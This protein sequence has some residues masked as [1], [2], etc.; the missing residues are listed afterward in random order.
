MLSKGVRYSVMI[1]PNRLVKFTLHKAASVPAIDRERADIVKAR[2]KLTK[3][4]TGAFSAMASKVTKQLNSLIKMDE[5]ELNRI[6]NQIDLDDYVELIGDID[7]I[8]AAIA[9]SGVDA[10]IIQVGLDMAVDFAQANELAIA[11]AKYH[12]AEMVGKKWV[13][14]VLV[15]NPNAAWSIRESTRESLRGLIVQA[16][17][18]GY[19]NQRLAKEIKEAYAFSA[20]RA[21]LIAR[22]ETA[23][24]DVMGNVI[25]Y[26]ESGVVKGKQWITAHDEKVTPD[27]AANGAQGV[28]DF[29]KAFS[30]GAM[31]PPDHP[32]CRCDVIPVLDMEKLEKAQARDSKGRFA[33]SGGSGAKLKAKLKRKPKQKPKGDAEYVD[34][35]GFTR[36]GGLNAKERKV[37]QDFYDK[38]R[39]SQAKL[40]AAYTK[41]NGHTVD[42]DL[43]KHLNKEFAHNQD[44]ARAVHEPSSHLSKII[45]N[46][47]LAEKGAA[48]DTSTTL[49]T[50]GGSGSGKS[51]TL[52]HAE[53]LLGAKS[54]GLVVDSVLSNFAS[55][56]SRIDATLKATS[57]DVGIVYTNAK[58]SQALRQNAARSRSVSIDTLLHAHAGASENVRVLA[59]HYKDNP[60][61]KVL[62][63]NN[64]GAKTDVHAGKLSDVPKYEKSTM[65]AQLVSE[66]NGMLSRGEITAQRHAL[67]IN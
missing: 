55:A 65:R 9:V 46:K 63:M 28:I 45:L 25:A 41:E 4:L 22:T 62:I 57:G 1:A 5:S 67:L 26:R 30:S 33:S 35:H 8:L 49:F 18:D 53:R 50:A 34:E 15:D 39:T 10:A 17:A 42:P 60:R 51:A 48:G 58:L 12:A 36:G 44:L 43:V 19:S 64:Q 2:T 7:D 61:V 38:I 47:F 29:D 37:E 54:G 66:A 21:M 24:A 6:L 27:C 32:R 23:S 59:D 16:T 56:K 14:G 20:D 11:W 40:I 13:D 31:F 3:L 52:P